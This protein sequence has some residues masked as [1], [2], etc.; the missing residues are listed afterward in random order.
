MISL[1]GM[2]VIASYSKALYLRIPYELQEEIL[3]LDDERWDTLVVPIPQRPGE[4]YYTSRV[5]LPDDR[6][7]DFQ[8]YL[9][10]KDQEERNAN[11]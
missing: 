7:L 2:R 5:H 9:N 10:R 4:N 3:G 1:S 6:V 11:L 8:K